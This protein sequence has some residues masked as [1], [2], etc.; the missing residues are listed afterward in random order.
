MP[1]PTTHV[2]AA[3]AKLAAEH[4][5]PTGSYCEWHTSRPESGLVV[6]P[7]EGCDKRSK[8]LLSTVGSEKRHRA[9]DNR[10]AL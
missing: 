2:R 7:S 4:G 10:P 9:H 5:M 8:A 3:T 6:Y 1:P